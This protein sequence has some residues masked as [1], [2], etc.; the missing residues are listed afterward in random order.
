MGEGT[1]F[2]GRREVQGE[3]TSMHEMYSRSDNPLC[4]GRRAT[5][6]CAA[7]TMTRSNLLP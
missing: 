1:L 6:S 7:R 2:L 3:N 4:S 5:K